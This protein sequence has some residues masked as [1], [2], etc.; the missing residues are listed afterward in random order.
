MGQ[1]E[2]LYA[3]NGKVTGCNYWKTTCSVKHM[4]PILSKRNERGIYAKIHIRMLK[5]SN[6]RNNPSI[7]QQVN[8]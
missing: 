4:L 7:H 8:G 2:F 6:T 1:I 5:A 3:D